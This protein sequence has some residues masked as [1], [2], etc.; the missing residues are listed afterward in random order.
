MTKINLYQSAY[1]PESLQN[2][3]AFC[4]PLLVDNQQALLFEYQHYSKMLEMNL[5]LNSEY[6]GLFSPKFYEKTRLAIPEVLDWI[7]QYPGYDAY[8]F[9]PF[10]HEA[11]FHFNQWECGERCHPGIKAATQVLFDH[12]A[13]GQ[14]DEFPRV[15]AAEVVYCNFWVGSTAFF[16]AYL[17]FIKAAADFMLS[18]PHIFMRETIH[19]GTNHLPFFPFILERLFTT[20]MLTQG[21][22][23]RYLPYLHA[24]ADYRYLIQWEPS[25][26]RLEKKFLQFCEVEKEIDALDAQ[27]QA[28]SERQAHIKAFEAINRQAA[29]RVG[30]PV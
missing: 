5:H 20:F 29:I 15:A 22:S 8:T 12:L 14:I 23:Y 4:Q 6:I 3:S 7:E 24:K 9:N 16:E 19:N 13:L 17:A 18:Q 1:S 10:P 30:L 27:Y 25:I 11:Y 2:I 28:V 26:G 21:R